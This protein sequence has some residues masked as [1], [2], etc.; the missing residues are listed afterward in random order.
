MVATDKHA[1]ATVENNNISNTSNI[2]GKNKESNRT[3]VKRSADGGSIFW[4]DMYDDEYDNKDPM[5]DD[6]T[7]KSAIKLDDLMGK[8]HWIGS[9]VKM[10]A[11]RIKDRRNR[12]KEKKKYR[13]VKNARNKTNTHVKR[14][15]PVLKDPGKRMFEELTANMKR[16][17]N[18]AAQAIHETTN[19]EGDYQ[20]HSI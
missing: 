11:K 13:N 7:D 18:E 17:C 8:D 3:V 10:L 1:N 14:S 20:Q 5:E 9:K 4:N 16:V 15:V 6:M 19:R 2:E 12:M